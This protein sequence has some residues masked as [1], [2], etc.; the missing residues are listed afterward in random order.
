MEESRKRRRRP[1]L[2][3]TACRRRKMRCDQVRPCSNCAQS[4]RYECIYPSEDFRVAQATHTAPLRR[5]QPGPIL[6][7]VQ[8]SSNPPSYPSSTVPQTRAQLPQS[9]IILPTPSHS[10]NATAATTPD[11][12]AL[13]SRISEL[14]SRVSRVS[15]ILQPN[16]T[17]HSGPDHAE[18][19]NT[20]RS[21]APEGSS[22][23]RRF[24]NQSSWIN[25]TTLVS[26]PRKRL[27]S[28]LY[29]DTRSIQKS[30]AVSA[31]R[32]KSTRTCVS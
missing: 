27:S 23:E 15:T 6:A 32:R 1:A 4:T 18:T 17:R 9:Q 22:T 28:S 3:C 12:A 13:L 25:L 7:P 24:A 26:P 20:Q 30:C 16:Q 29:S 14:E 19:T 10:S 11:V 5:P 2:A 21:V 8:A 31:A